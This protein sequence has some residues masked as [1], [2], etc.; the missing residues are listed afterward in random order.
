MMYYEK[1][2]PHSLQTFLK[3]PSHDNL[4]E[5]LLHNSGE[6]DFLD[7]K[8]KWNNFSKLAKHILAIA[9]S[10]GGS[11][12]VGVSQDEEGIAALS[13][14][15]EEDYIDKADIDNKLQHLLPKYLKY[16]VEDFYF[17]NHEHPGLNNKLFQVLLI[18]YDPKYV[19]YTSVSNQNELRYGAVY[20]RQGTKSLEATN[21]KLVEIIVRK[22]QTGV[23][24]TSELTLKEH[25]GQ[26]K[27]LFEELEVTTAPPEYVDF[28]K[29]LIK[30][31]KKR[32]QQYMDLQ[33]D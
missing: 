26:L 28:L 25:L 19:P 30:S 12:I 22:V 32:V 11:I 16:R 20:I 14:V 18:E 13:G 31:K 4:K 9:N 15:R 21:E 33:T 6:T 24:D 1:V 10:G 17:S 7:F 2:V 29:Q 23:A 27:S 8:M 3:N 5:L